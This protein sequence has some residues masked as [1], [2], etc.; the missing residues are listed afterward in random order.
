MV[1][2]PCRASR[3]CWCSA[4]D[5]GIP[6]IPR[7]GACATGAVASGI[8][9]I[10]EALI[11]AAIVLMGLT[12]VDQSTAR[13]FSISMHLV[14][15][16]LLLA[17]LAL[18]A[19]WAS[20]GRALDPGAHPWHT[21]AMGL[22]LFGL[23]LTGTAGALTALGDTL[24][25]ASSLA[26]GLQQDVNPAAHFLVPLRVLHPIIAIF[27]GMYLLYLTVMLHGRDES[28][29]RET[30]AGASLSRRRTNSCGRDQRHFTR[31]YLDADCPSPAR[32]HCLDS[33]GA[34]HGFRPSRS[35][36]LKHKP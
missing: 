7:A 26:A 2:A 22:G 25:P 24:F 5:L 16:F 36:R 8:F 27:T 6:Q 15:T 32:R 33:H 12:G 20:G 9:I 4:G 18:T 14:N 10:I 29:T 19:W 23:V 17:A 28:T 13:V 35:N 11:G 21:A 30:I 1:I 3:W 31:P 34:L